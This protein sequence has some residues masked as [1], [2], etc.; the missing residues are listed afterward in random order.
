[1]R[2]RQLVLTLIPLLNLY[3]TRTFASQS[4]L[5]AM[6]GTIIT[7]TDVTRLANGVEVQNSGIPLEGKRK[8]VVED[9]LNLFSSKPS[10]DILHRTWRQD[11][12]FEDPLSKC[13]GYKEFAPQ[14]YGLVGEKLFPTSRTLSYKVI[15]S[16]NDPRRITYEQQQEYTVRFIG[17]KKLM[18][19]TVVI[20]LDENDQIVKLEDKWNGNDQPT[21]FGALTMYNSS[22]PEP[23]L[24]KAHLLSIS[25][26][27]NNLR[28]TMTESHG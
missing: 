22:L 23:M 24:D 28:S 4:V 17:T 1:M 14:W 27:V 10:Q 11:A 8:Q 9:V 15:S 20:D 7:N 5:S 3:A 18:N 2:T 13:F 16:T 26:Q 6:S 19:S 25:K 21:R 12:I